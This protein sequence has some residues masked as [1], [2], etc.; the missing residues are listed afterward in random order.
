MVNI[1]GVKPGSSLHHRTLDMAEINTKLGFKAYEIAKIGADT[2]RATERTD[3]L[4][5]VPTVILGARASRPL[6]KVTR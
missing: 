6:L 4:S 1:V 2:L 5:V 3:A